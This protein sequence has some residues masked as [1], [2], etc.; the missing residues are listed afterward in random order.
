MSSAGMIQW[1]P[2]PNTD[3]TRLVKKYEK[4][5]ISEPSNTT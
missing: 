2:I 1:M 3:C 4:M 5:P